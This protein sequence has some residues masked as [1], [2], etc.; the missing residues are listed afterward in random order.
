MDIRDA[1]PADDRPL[2]THYADAKLSVVN[3]GHTVQVNYPPGSWANIAGKRYELLQFHLHGPSENTVNGEAMAMETHLVHNAED[4]S[5]AVLGVLMKEGA[6]SAPLHAVQDHLPTD[7]GE[8]H[9]WDNVTFNVGDSLP[10]TAG[11]WHFSG[12]LTTP[13]CTEGV[14]WN[15]LKTPLEVSHE[16]VEAFSALLYGNARPVQPL[17]GRVIES[18]G[19]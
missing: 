9:T 12:S 8:V 2:E 19:G 16:Q 3:N 14:D 17:E 5:L 18:F 6:D 4:G 11:Y 10:E 15:V 1:V 7:V 13:P